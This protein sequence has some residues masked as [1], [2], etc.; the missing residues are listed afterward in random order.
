MINNMEKHRLLIYNIIY[1]F[2]VSNYAD[3]D[4]KIKIAITGTG[5]YAEL[6]VRT[7]VWAAQGD[8]I[9]IKITVTEI[10][11]Y[12]KLLGM[13]PEFFNTE[14]LSDSEDINY[15]I[16]FSESNLSENVL[17][18]ECSENKIVMTALDKSSIAFSEN[19]SFND[20]IFL[21]GIIEKTAKR[22]FNPWKSAHSTERDDEFFLSEFNYN[23]S[24]AAALFWLIRK[25]LN[26]DISVNDKNMRLEHRRWNTYMRSE[27][28]R[29]A[30]IRDNEKKTHPC[31]VQY[32]ELTEE[33][34][35]YD[36]NPIRS[37]NDITD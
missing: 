8:N 26:E 3:D 18:F 24:C 32:D 27:G 9:N 5:A 25:K 21:N 10:D 17:H 36:A 16:R 23:S 28:Y 29:Y 1:N 20:D 6:L 35:A 4:K 7:L 33:I 37:V 22:I 34:Q 19:F 2:P 15:C 31:L 30:H 14:A 13:C 12:N 11:L